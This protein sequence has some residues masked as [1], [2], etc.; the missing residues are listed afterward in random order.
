M[1]AMRHYSFKPSLFSL[2]LMLAGLTLFA[3]LGVWQLDR[4]AERDAINYEREQRGTAPTLVLAS[5]ETVDLAVLRYRSVTLFGEY[6]PGHEF[7]LDNQS[8]AGVVGFHVLT[9]FRVKGSAVAVIINRGWIPMG[10]DRLHPVIPRPP[11]EGPVMLS[12]L[13]DDLYRVGFQLEGA[14]V[15]GAGWPSLVQ[16]PDAVQMSARLQYPLGAYQVL[17]S[18][19][20][21]GGFGRSWHTRRLDADKNRGYALQWFLL[22]ALALVLFVRHG[23]KR[24]PT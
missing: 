12:G 6:D 16:V 19:Q 14:A 20:V 10:T 1:T 22:A 18:A 4:A 7:L 23:L 15:P 21:D 11:P 24:S 2:I 5:P 3:R 8:E 13:I 17:L 9:P